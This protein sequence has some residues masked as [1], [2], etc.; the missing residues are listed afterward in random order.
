MSEDVQNEPEEVSAEVSAEAEAYHAQQA[1]LAQQS[2][3]ASHQALIAAVYDRYFA[4]CLGGT[5]SAPNIDSNTIVGRAS[6]IATK[7]VRRRTDDLLK[8]F[9]EFGVA[10]PAAPE[11]HEQ[12]Q[13]PPVPMQAPQ[14]QVQQQFA[15]SSPTAQS[16]GGRP[17]TQT[18]QVLP[19]GNAPVI[20]PPGAAP[21]PVQRQTVQSV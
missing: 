13:T 11:T 3:L 1:E 10:A 14:A 16:S 17:P 20:L 7:A 19:H 9:V 6:D 12:H 8:L 21:P 2:I 5:S 18:S 15:R 4:E